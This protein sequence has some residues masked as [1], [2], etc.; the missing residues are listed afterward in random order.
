MFRIILFLLLVLPV[1]VFGYEC[2]QEIDKISKEYRIRISC[3]PE[4]IESFHVRGKKPSQ[5][6]LEQ[7]TPYLKNFINSYNSEILK[8]QIGRAHV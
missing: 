4:E 7:F 3:S 6:Y 5:S 8:R 2:N 1:N